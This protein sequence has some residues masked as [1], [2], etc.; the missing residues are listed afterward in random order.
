MNRLFKMLIGSLLYL[1]MQ[2]STNC[3]ADHM[4]VIKNRD[5]QTDG[6]LESLQLPIE[7]RPKVRDIFQSI[8]TRHHIE[9]LLNI[10]SQKRS[11]K[12]LKA[13]LRLFLPEFRI[14][15]NVFGE[16]IHEEVIT[17]EILHAYMLVMGLPFILRFQFPIQGC[18]TDLENIIQHFYIFNKMEKIG[19]TAYRE[20]KK[21][22]EQQ[23]PFFSRAARNISVLEN[24]E[25][26]DAVGVTFTLGG[27]ITGIT[28]PQ[29]APIT[30]QRFKKSL[31]ISQELLEILEKYNLMKY[32]DAFKLRMEVCSKIG[33]KSEQ[34]VIGV[35]DFSACKAKYYN[36]ETGKLIVVK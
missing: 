11:K 2:Q 24:D 22:W 7:V 9:F 34:V 20:A 16:T 17:H 35:L 29:I 6:T 26:I 13:Q 32:E 8:H 5:H 3:L 10:P 1:L 23:V 15:I 14:E 12:D 31:S 27:I 33:L 19:F 4:I 18:I 30:P 21:D 25:V 28:K 36:I